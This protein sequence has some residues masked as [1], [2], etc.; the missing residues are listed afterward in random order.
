MPTTFL[1]LP[2]ELRD[3]IYKLV[4]VSPSSRIIPILSRSSSS[5][6]PSSSPTTPP[7]YHL[8][9]LPPSNSLSTPTPF[10]KDPTTTLAISP[11]LLRTNRQIYQEAKPL[12][13]EHNT[14]YFR[15]PASL[16]A[17]LKHIG[18]IASRLLVS[19]ALCNPPVDSSSNN[20]N[21]NS[22][23][24]AKAL[25]LL[26]SR[27]RHGRFR[28]LELEMGDDWKG[29]IFMREGYRGAVGAYD[30]FLDVLRAAG[31]GRYEKILRAKGGSRAAEE[32]EVLKECHFAWGGKAFWDDEL[33]WEDYKLVERDRGGGEI[34][35]LMA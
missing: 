31:E 6:S 25:S 26:G 34:G 14:F 2:F 17:V 23:A 12:F 29:L 33:V 27:S 7:H 3:Q 21:N 28:R 24:L 10:S 4:L 9:C 8:R 19:I 35:Y 1:D 22:Q 15:S 18:Q 16:R 30:A 20:N 32:R 13:W 5:S 11:S